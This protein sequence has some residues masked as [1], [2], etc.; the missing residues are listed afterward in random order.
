MISVLLNSPRALHL[1]KGGE[2][3]GG[4]VYEMGRGIFKAQTV[5]DQSLANTS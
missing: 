3:E 2:G 5:V 4:A 1:M